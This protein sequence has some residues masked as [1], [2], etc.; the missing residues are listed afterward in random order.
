MS[1]TTV[2]DALFMANVTAKTAAVQNMTKLAADGNSFSK[3]MNEATEKP[4]GQ[5]RADGN[6]GGEGVRKSK[7][8]VDKPAGKVQDMD[9]KSRTKGAKDQEA[10]NGIS[11]D[12]KEALVSEVTEKGFKIGNAIT[13]KFDAS[14]EEL[15]EAMEVLGLT[16]V[17]LLDPANLRNL[18][19]EVTETGDSLELLTNVE[20]YEGMKEIVSIA[21]EM[22]GEIKDTDRKSTR[23]NSSH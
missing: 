17:D 18:I 9:G 23:L 13:E 11:D 14:D 4:D 2:T 5:G 16:G 15:S 10:G 1:K 6:A 7:T 20:L 21:D 3:A 8:I 12:V 22:V 19:M